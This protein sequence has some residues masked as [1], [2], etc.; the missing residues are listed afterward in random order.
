MQEETGR[1]EGPERN[2]SKKR[3]SGKEEVTEEK[4]FESSVVA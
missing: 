3:N 4:V 1:G 2:R